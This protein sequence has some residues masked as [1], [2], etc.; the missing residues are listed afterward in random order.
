MTMI[1][2]S[3]ATKYGTTREVA[4]CVGKT[5]CERGIE[6]E[7]RP[8][9]EVR[10][11]TGYSA[12]VLGSAL[13]YFMLHRDAKRFLSRHRQALASVPIALFALGPFNDTPEEMASA[14]APIDKYLAK[15]EW[16]SPVSVA[17][18]G[19]RH[20]PALLRFPD[21]NPAMRNM[22]P[23]DARDWNAIRAW[24]G[25]LPQALGVPSS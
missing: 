5:L 14:R 9:D 21:N 11:L 24:A 18:F 13:Y 7:V 4:E 22:P 3:Y 17:V 25:G 12:V 1:L 19:G 2:V 16:L 15:H 8:A 23:S 6:A 10:D 20:D